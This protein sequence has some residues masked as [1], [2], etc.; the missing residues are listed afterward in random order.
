MALPVTGVCVGAY[1]VTRGVVNSAEALSS[2]SKGMVWNEE[3]REWFYYR[4]DEEVEEVERLDEEQK[5]NETN[6][7]GSTGTGP[8]RKVKDD[9]YYKLLGVEPNATQGEIKKAYYVKARKCHPDKNPGDPTAP[10]R[11]QELGHAYQVLANAR[12]YKRLYH[13]RG[14]RRISNSTRS[15]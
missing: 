11:F 8:S 3:T 15:Y 9:S 7:S 10:G 14:R 2:A 6:G 13:I 4:L 1:Q 12:K 5:N